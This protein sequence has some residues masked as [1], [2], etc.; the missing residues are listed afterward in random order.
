MGFLMPLWP[1]SVVGVLLCAL[2]G[3]YAFAVCVALLLDLAWG[4]PTGR[5][6]YLYFPFTA[7]ALCASIVRYFGG[8]YVLDRQHQEK[9]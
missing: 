5:F 3:R 9:L 7:L 1:L 4:A 2:S 6:M 8:R